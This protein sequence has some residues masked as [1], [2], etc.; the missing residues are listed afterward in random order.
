M[1]PKKAQ[2]AAVKLSRS[3]PKCGCGGIMPAVRSATYLEEAAMKVLQHAYDEG[4][5]VLVDAEEAAEMFQKG[6]MRT[7]DE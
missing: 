2:E 5:Y 3:C 4:R 7:P 1:N 6:T